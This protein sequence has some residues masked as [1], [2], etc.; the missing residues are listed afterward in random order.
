M[1]VI[2]TKTKRHVRQEYHS[3]PVA[4]D[5]AALSMYIETGRVIL[6][7]HAAARVEVE[8]HLRDVDM[9]VWREGDCVHIAVENVTTSLASDEIDPEA[10][11]LLSVPATCGILAHVVT[12]AVEINDLAADVR[13]HVITGSTCLRNVAGRIAASAVTGT[14]KYEG[15]LTD[16]THRFVTTTGALQL[17][18]QQPPDARIYGWVTTGRVFCDLPL[19]HERR[20]GFPTGDH[21]YGVAGS[22][23]GRILAEVTTGSIQICGRQ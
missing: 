19:S 3:E 22:G 17:N 10:E 15:R 11:L 12:G 14:I 6:T 7:T 4:P 16:D 5:A 8:A 23:V 2:A 20:G 21:L 13:T 1:I 18:L 9:R